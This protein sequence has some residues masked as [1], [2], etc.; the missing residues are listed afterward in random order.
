MPAPSAT[1]APAAAYAQYFLAM[2]EAR[3]ADDAA[4][5][6][7]AGL[8]LEEALAPRERQPELR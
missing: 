8:A 2:L 5:S 7:A 6:R 3:S 4:L 1:A